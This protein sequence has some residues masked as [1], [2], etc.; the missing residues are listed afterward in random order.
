MIAD[1][2]LSACSGVTAGVGNTLFLANWQATGLPMAQISTALYGGNPSV[3]TPG[4]LDL[5]SGHVSCLFSAPSADDWAIDMYFD[6]ATIP[7]VASGSIGFLVGFYGYTLYLS[8]NGASW[9]H[10]AV[11]PAGTTGRNH[12]A[13]GRQAGQMQAWLNGTRFLSGAASAAYPWPPS[14]DFQIS[15][16]GTIGPVRIVGADIYGD[17]ATI[18]VPT[19]PLG[20]V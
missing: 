13:M 6:G 20:I 7:G 11:I 19:L 2:L 17:S 14:A 5:G 9:T 4:T 16:P 3:S 15:A 1:M 12:L 10:S 8:D 18:T